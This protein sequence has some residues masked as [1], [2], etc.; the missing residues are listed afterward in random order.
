MLL[1]LFFISQLHAQQLDIVVG[2][3]SQNYSLSELRQKL[4]LIHVTNVDP[5]YK[6]KKTFLGFPLKRI[7]ELVGPIPADLDELS[8]SA[9]DGY[10]PS[11]SLRDALTQNG[12]IAFNLEPALQNGKK[13]DLNPFYLVWEHE[14]KVPEHF[15]RPYQLVKIELMKFS[16]KFKE[17]FPLDANDS[18][19]NGFKSFRDFCFRCHAINGTGGTL[20]PELN[21]PNNVLEYWNKTKLK[22]F[23]KDPSAFRANSKMPVTTQINDKD[24]D[25]ILEYFEAMK[26]HKNAGK[27]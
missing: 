13:V 18:V 3:K 24:I 5:V 16:E 11:I 12:V 21:S 6:V 7:I 14:E 9:K 17:I 2:G 27:K 10:S 1:F 19:K 26:S 15:P 25:S 8:F 22:S 4:P 20:G 23:I